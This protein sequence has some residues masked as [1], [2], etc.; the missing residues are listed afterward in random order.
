MRVVLISAAAVALCAMAEAGSI[1][2]G[3]LIIDTNTGYEGWQTAGPGAIPADFDSVMYLAPAGF[4]N[5]APITDSQLRQ[6]QREA[7]PTLIVMA[8]LGFILL[9]GVL[10]AVPQ[11]L[12]RLKAIRLE[13]E[14]REGRRRKVKVEMRMM[15]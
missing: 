7:P 12:R 3:P 13:R 4:L 2:F 14:R 15:A 10:R 5:A 9:A 11:G 6:R 1:G 8:G